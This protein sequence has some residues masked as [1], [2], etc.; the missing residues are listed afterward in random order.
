MAPLRLSI[1]WHLFVLAAL[2]LLPQVILGAYVA[3]GYAR[4]ARVA[5]ER[6]AQTLTDVLLQSTD[7]EVVGVTGVLKGLAV[8]QTLAREDFGAF[9]QQAAS[10]IAEMPVR[11]VA[12]R[13]RQ[14][15]QRVNTNASWGAP[16]PAP[17][18]VSLS[19]DRELFAS[20]KPGV[21]V[22][23]A[24][25]VSRAPL[26]LVGVPIF[27]DG[28]PVYTLSAGLTPDVIARVLDA[29]MIPEGWLC[30][31]LDRDGQVIARSR[32]Q[33]RYLGARASQEFMSA[34]TG[35][36]GRVE[37]VTLD[38]V[39]VSTTFRRSALSG[40]MVLV[41]VPRPL[42]D[43]PVRAL[44]QSL[45]A[46]GALGV[47]TSALAGAL[48][49]RVIGGSLLRLSASAARSGLGDP[50]GPLE[51]SVVEVNDVHRALTDASTELAKRTAHQTFLMAELD[52]RVKNTLAVI[53]S[54]IGR[55]LKGA[56]STEHAAVSLRGRVMA[57]ARAHEMLSD[58]RWEP[59]ELGE[60]VRAVTQSDGI[61]VQVDGP[62]V[63]LPPKSVVAMAQTIHELAINR[64]RHG[65]LA[66]GGSVG[67]R[68]SV[69]KGTLVWQ[70]REPIKAEKV[71]VGSGFGSQVIRLCVERQLGG[72]A[73]FKVE[74]GELVFQATI[75]L[76]HSTLGCMAICREVMSPST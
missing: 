29:R 40:W 9:Y 23:H 76:D 33:D 19:F 74:R 67:V 63:L 61:S 58:A 42:L 50:S 20:R 27:T 62:P 32:D 11:G 55:T 5:T 10:A 12:V 16:L 71:H 47:V 39:P 73:T 1:R 18:D 68:W 49:S 69:E 6:S 43:V 60:L 2:I 54:L 66:S 64:A 56:K 52:H 26:V 36:N 31:V 45:L 28:Q 51:T 48:Y 3:Y 72:E 37:S 17:N 13:D 24:G 14:G 22:L 57:L 25:R 21:S 46:L 41:S 15:N 44:W 65:E 35:D 7:R 30:V 34:A 75:P 53:Q 4:D 38:G 70:W 59:V 8:A